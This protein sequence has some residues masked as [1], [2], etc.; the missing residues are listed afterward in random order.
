MKNKYYKTLRNTL[1]LGSVLLLASCDRY[2]DINENPNNIHIEEV[3]PDL[4]FLGA[5]TQLYRTQANNLNIF[6]NLMMNGWA[7]NS[8]VY[9]SPYVREFNLNSVDN[10][11]YNAIWD[12][13]YRSM[14]NYKLIE[15]YPNANGAQDNYVATSKIMKAFYMQTIVDLY[16]DA[17][18]SDAFK[19]QT[20]LTPKYDD[21]VAIYHTEIEDLEKAIALIDG[22]NANAIA[23]TAGTDPVFSGV[24]ADWRSFANTVKL[25]YLM[26][27]SKLTGAEATYR[28]AKLAGLS[29]ATFIS[30]DV[31]INP[32]YNSST[33]TQQNPFYGTYIRTSAG[34]RVGQAVTVS[35]HQANALNGNPGAGLVLPGNPTNIYDKYTGLVDPRR[36]RLWTTVSG[37][38]K[39]VRQGALSGEPGAP[40]SGSNPVSRIG[41]GITGEPNTGSSAATV[42]A[43]SSKSGVIMSLSEIKFMLAEAALTFPTYFS[44]A[45]GNFE[46]GITASFT[47]LGATGSAAYITSANTRAGLG[48]TGSNAQ[49]LEAIMTQAWIA[50]TSINPIQSFINYN[51]TGYPYTPLAVTTTK[52]NKPYRLVYPVSEFVANSSNVPNVTSADVFVKN[53]FTPF[54]NQ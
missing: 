10:S 5:T 6:G 44:N 14:G 18:L 41:L 32:G 45:Q 25:R 23:L 28:N 36:S 43:G 46:S 17:P 21:D 38:L 29:S 19:Y 1:L 35:E 51:K 54:W 31:K 2:L 42:A 16:G 52:A 50:N 34:S 40:Q 27:M 53:A 49:K 7:G 48:W 8:Y 22:V 20:N 11:F 39:G 9:G 24:M 26:R 15:E 12:G 13:L 30:A 33:D 3:S 4:L 37:A 47:Y